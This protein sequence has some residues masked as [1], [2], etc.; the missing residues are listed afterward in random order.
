MISV[1]FLASGKDLAKRSE[2]KIITQDKGILR[3]SNTDGIVRMKRLNEI[4]MILGL[5]Q[6]YIP[7]TSPIILDKMSDV[8]RINEIMAI[9]VNPKA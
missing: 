4:I 6:L 5:N 1:I 7:S 2:R 3:P 8:M 9:T